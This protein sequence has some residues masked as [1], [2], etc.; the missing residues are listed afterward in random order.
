M[1]ERTRQW[2]TARRL[3][4]KVEDMA[5]TVGSASGDRKRESH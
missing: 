5:T 3:V 4:S 1:A 2:S